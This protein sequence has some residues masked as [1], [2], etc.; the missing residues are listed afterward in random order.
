MYAKDYCLKTKDRSL[1]DVL[2]RKGA[3]INHKDFYGKTLVNYLT[4]NQKAFLGL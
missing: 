2:I 1:F 3:D 4:E